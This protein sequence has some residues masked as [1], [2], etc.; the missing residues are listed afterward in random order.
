MFANSRLSVKIEFFH[1][2][3]SHCFTIAM[4]VFSG[5]FEAFG[6]QSMSD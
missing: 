4:S 1:I 6:R 5:G 2:L 3:V